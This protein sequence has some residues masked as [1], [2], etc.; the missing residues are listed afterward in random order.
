MLEQ[1]LSIGD[2]RRA[3]SLKLEVSAWAGVPV[4]S[5]RIVRS[6]YRAC[7]LGAHVDHQMGAVTGFALDRAVM[8]AFAPR[9]DGIVEVRSRQFAGTVR[10]GTREPATPAAGEWGDY[11]RGAVLALEGRLRWGMTAVVDGFD[12]VGGLSSSAAV[13]IA[14]LLA[15]EAANGLVLSTRENIE[16]D[17][18]IENDYIGLSNGILDQSMILLSRPDHL[19]H[20]DCRSGESELV[21]CGAG[22]GVSIGV[23]FS[24]LRTPLAQTDYNL[25]V[26]ECR[27]AAEGL[28]RAADLPVPEPVLLRDVPAETHA[29]H[30]AALPAR[31]RR[32]ADHFFGEQERVALGVGLW[33]QGD[34]AE[35]GRLVT[36]SGQSSIDNYE[37]GNPYL[38]TAYEVLRDCPGVYGARFSGAGFRG[39]CIALVRPG[40]AQTVA[41]TALDA[42]VKAHPD[43]AGDAG[44]YWCSLG[45][46]AG[47]LDPEADTCG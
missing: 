45:D 24:G 47:V 28:L 9:E 14:Y 43:M 42:Y 30:R 39:C 16:L 13:G 26:G 29:R 18:V 3:E 19:T 8:L 10:A 34:M 11:A 46:G 37:C 35:F 1:S 23:L 31:L 38:C 20:L 2:R 44:F 5:V 4:D 25:R 36:E 17:R 12:D 41:G 21:P 15:L 40:M 27:A 6:P 22:E 33:R 32:R 7:P